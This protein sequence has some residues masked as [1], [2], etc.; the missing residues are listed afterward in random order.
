M[1]SFL[2]KTILVYSLESLIQIDGTNRYLS[3]D[4]QTGSVT[5]KSCTMCCCS[6]EFINMRDFAVQFSNHYFECVRLTPQTRIKY[7]CPKKEL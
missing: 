1:E 4:L 7:W 3:E 5:S 2:D 6:T